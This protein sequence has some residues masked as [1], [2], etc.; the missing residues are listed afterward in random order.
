MDYIMGKCVI[1]IIRRDDNNILLNTTR[2]ITW[3]S[4]K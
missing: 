4:N 2:G 1:C 3:S